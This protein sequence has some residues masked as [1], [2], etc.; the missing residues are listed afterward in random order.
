MTR[1]E[2]RLTWKAISLTGFIISVLKFIP[3]VY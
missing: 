1:L 3:P 2:A